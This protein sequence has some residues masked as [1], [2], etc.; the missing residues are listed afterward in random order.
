MLRFT[1][2]NTTPPL[3]ALFNTQ[4]RDVK[5]KFIKGLATLT[6]HRLIWMDPSN[7]FPPMAL[8]HSHISSV[9]SAVLLYAK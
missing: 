5:S 6:T 1:K 3:S 8:Q 7:K 4:I 9:A 2:G